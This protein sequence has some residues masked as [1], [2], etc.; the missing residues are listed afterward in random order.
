MTVTT[1]RFVAAPYEPNTASLQLKEIV[2]SIPKA[3]FEKNTI[4]AW[5]SVMLSVSAVILGYC[6][7]V[8]LPAYLLPFSWFFTGTALTG[9]FVIGHDAGHRSFAKRRWV[10]DVVGHLFFRTANL[11]IPS[12]AFAARPS[13]FAYEQDGRG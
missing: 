4:K 3:Y 5:K 1:E 12:L 7:I 2:K 10:N 11:S 9:F 6:A 13:S 8:F